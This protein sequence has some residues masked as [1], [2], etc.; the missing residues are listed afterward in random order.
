MK[1]LNTV[2]MTVAVKGEVA[3]PFI[4]KES[5]RNTPVSVLNLDTRSSNAFKRNKINTIGEL[6]DIVPKLNE[7]RGLGA[8][9][10]S[11]IMYELCAFTYSSL[12]EKRK[13]EYLEK[14]IKLNT[15]GR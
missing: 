6:L 11:R 3:Y 4:E 2:L 10:K 1:I 15:E 8:K 5:I 7:L 9:S 13:K 14:I 12:D